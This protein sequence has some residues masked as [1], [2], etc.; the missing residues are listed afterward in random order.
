M[1]KETALIKTLRAILRVVWPGWR[2]EVRAPGGPCVYVCSHHN[3]HG[4]MMTV[5]WLGFPVRLWVLNVF[6]DRESCR[7][8]YAEYTFSKRF[9]MKPWLA[10]LCAGIASG[11]VSHIV[12]S[13]GAIPVWR[14]SSRIQETF[15]DSIA[16]LK[17]GDRLAIFPDVAYSGEQ[18]GIGEIYEGFLLLGRMYARD[19][20]QPLPFIPLYMDYERKT[21]REGTPVSYDPAAKPKEERERLAKALREQINAMAAGK[22]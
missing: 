6:F 14:G 18:E 15:R 16:A 22:A 12:R 13:T 19:T 17:A 21:I 20:G 4:P 3:L 1:Q 7:K 9:G 8:Q 5:V 2:S 11:A 10:D